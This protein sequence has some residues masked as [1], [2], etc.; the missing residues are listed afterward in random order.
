VT[1]ILLRPPCGFIAGYTIDSKCGKPAH[2]QFELD[3]R[4][5]PDAKP[6]IIQFA[7]EVHGKDAR[8]LNGL[9]YIKTI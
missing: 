4:H 2:Y 8:E 5:W 7:C 3:P 6:P 9:I 1:G